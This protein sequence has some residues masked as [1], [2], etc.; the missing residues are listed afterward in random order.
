MKKWLA[1][2]LAAF[3]AFGICFAGEYV[4]GMALK[5]PQ[6]IR[7]FKLRGSDGLPFNAASLRGHWS[8]V[9]FGYT[10]CL[11]VCPTTLASLRRVYRKLERNL[12]ARLVPQVVMVSV[13]P[14]RDTVRQM[15]DYV[16]QFNPAFIGARANMQ[17]VLQLSDQFH[18]WF[19]K[20]PSHDG[21]SRHYHIKHSP[22]IFLV[23]PRGK[24]VATLSYP[25]RVR[26][27]VRDYEAL[28]S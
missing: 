7:H 24:W 26:Q 27:T 5:H 3:L 28:V 9:F 16:E 4:D 1:L 18:V 6:K 19:Y 17:H 11:K 23:N 13:D 15:R 14:A 20:K 25:H 8:M 21:N 22:E 2:S 12:P 10:R